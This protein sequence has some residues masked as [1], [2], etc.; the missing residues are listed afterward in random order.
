MQM[1]SKCE[2]YLWKA[3]IRMENGHVQWATCVCCDRGWFALC[4][5]ARTLKTQY[6]FGGLSLAICESCVRTMGID[7]NLVA[8]LSAGEVH[9]CYFKFCQCVTE[10]G[11]PVL[12]LTCCTKSFVVPRVAVRALP[13]IQLH[14]SNVCTKPSIQSI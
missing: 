14:V 11:L 13:C 3:R 5:C 2:T 12:K 4:S 1:A 10:S 7:P 6:L 8:S 9:F